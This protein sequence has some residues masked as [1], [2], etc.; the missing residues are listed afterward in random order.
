MR[1]KAPPKPPMKGRPR[2]QRYL[3]LSDKIDKKNKA[4]KKT[5]NSNLTWIT[6]HCR[7]CKM[8][9]HNRTANEPNEKPL[10]S[11]SDSK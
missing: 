1:I 9:R 11:F 2:T 10:I 4:H 3:A 7:N 6:R 5:G 8:T